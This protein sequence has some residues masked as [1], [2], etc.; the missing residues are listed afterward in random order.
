[1]PPVRFEEQVDSL[2]DAVAQKDGC[3]RQLEAETEHARRE[4][5]P[6]VQELVHALEGYNTLSA[7]IHDSGLQL[8]VKESG[9]GVAAAGEILPERTRESVKVV[10]AVY[11][12]LARERAMVAGL[13]EK[14]TELVAARHAQ[15]MVLETLTRNAEA[16]EIARAQADAAYECQL[17][18]ARALEAE[19]RLVS[20]AKR[21]LDHEMQLLQMQH[22]RNA[23]AAPGRS[24]EARGGVALLDAAD[25]GSDGDGAHALHALAVAHEDARRT[26]AQLDEVE[27]RVLPQTQAALSAL[28]HQVADAATVYARMRCVVEGMALRIWP[29]GLRQSEDARGETLR[30]GEWSAT[31]GVPE[32]A[33]HAA[34]L[35]EAMRQTLDTLEQ[36]DTHYAVQQERGVALAADFARATEVS[37]E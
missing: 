18:R 30:P 10:E 14:V 24:V 6:L 2:I 12:E 13:Q 20:E 21:S 28:T 16:S 35:C 36:L 11:A 9:V 22:A 26:R 29:D 15:E 4:K 7:A 19:L 1:M 23:S 34:G 31:A 25:A 8:D 37:R 32:G 3:I 17:G 27:Q 33:E 5:E